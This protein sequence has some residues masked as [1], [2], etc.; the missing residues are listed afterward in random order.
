MFISP[1]PTATPSLILVP[2]HD[3]RNGMVVMPISP[4]NVNEV[5][6]GLSNTAF[7]S[8]R[9]VSFAG[10]K[11]LDQI[12]CNTLL[13]PLDYVS[14]GAPYDTMIHAVESNWDAWDKVDFSGH[15][16]HGVGLTQTG[17]NHVVT[18][19]HRV[20]IEMRGAIHS[21]FG[22]VGPTSHHP[23]G[24]NLCVGDGS[25]RFVTDQIDG[26]IWTA[27]ATIAGAD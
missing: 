13:R 23:G 18:P 6:D 10:S 26:Y 2:W 24:V 14:N 27:L 17:Y 16:W 11:G 21:D 4:R 12:A 5:S 19:N 20:A 3:S 9:L 8:E 1:V 22:I 7:S 15:A 25:V